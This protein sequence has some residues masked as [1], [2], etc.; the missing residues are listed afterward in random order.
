[1]F[2]FVDLTRRDISVSRFFE[3]LDAID[4]LDRDALIGQ[5]ALALGI[6]VGDI[7]NEEAKQNARYQKFKKACARMRLMDN[8]ILRGVVLDILSIHQKWSDSSTIDEAIKTLH[9]FIEFSK[10]RG[11]TDEELEKWRIMAEQKKV[12]KQSDLQVSRRRYDLFCN[13]VVKPLIQ[14]K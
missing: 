9:G 7:N 12:Q 6:R 14:P 13:E 8:I 1:M 3:L 5:T 10:A 11:A 2:P 4:S